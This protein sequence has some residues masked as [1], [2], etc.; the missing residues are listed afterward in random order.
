MHSE[1]SISILNEGLFNMEG[2]SVTAKQNHFLVATP[3][4]SEIK[5]AVFGLKEEWLSGTR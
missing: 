1:S 2:P 3:S 4:P 5:E